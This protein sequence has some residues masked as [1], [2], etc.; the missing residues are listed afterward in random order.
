MLSGSS[1]N[2][3]ASSITN[4]AAG[5]L[6]SATASSSC[7][8][9]AT[10][11]AS[12]GGG[13]Y[14]AAPS[15]TSTGAGPALV[16]TAC[17]L[18]SNTAAGDGGG[19]TVLSGRAVLTAG[20][21]ANNI[22]GGDGGGVAVKVSTAGWLWLHLLQSHC[23]T[24]LAPPQSQGQAVLAAASVLSNTAG[25]NGGGIAFGVTSQPGLVAVYGGSVSGNTAG[26]ASLQ[27]GLGGGLYLAWPAYVVQGA[28][29][30]NNSAYTGGGLSIAADFGTSQTACRLA[31]A[32]QLPCSAPLLAVVLSGNNASA[33]L[34]LFWLRASSPGAVVACTNCTLPWPL[35]P[36][37]LATEPLSLGFATP[38]ATSVQTGSVM[39]QWSIALQD[40]YASAAATYAA[41]C[42]LAT[43]APLGGVAV[44]DATRLTVE[45]NQAV[46]ALGV[47]AFNSTPH[48]LVGTT[49]P[50]QVTCTLTAAATALRPVGFNITVAPCAAGTQVSSDGRSCDACKA[51]AEFNLQAGGTC[52]PCPLGGACPTPT[53]LQALPDWWRSTNTS[54]VLFNCPLA[55]ACLPGQP[56]GDAACL[57]GYGGPVCAVCAP[58]YYPWGKVCK[59]CDP[60]FNWSMPLVGAVAAVAFVCMFALPVKTDNVDPVVRAKL[61]MTFLQ[62]QGL[63]KDYAITWR[64]K[65]L[66][67]A[68]SYFDVLNI[69]L[70]I[71]A[72]AC[73]KA[74]LD[75]Y[76]TYLTTMMLPPAALGLCAAVWAAHRWALRGPW[77]Q[78]RPQP[79]ILF[80]RVLL[81]PR[82]ALS[83]DQ[84]AVAL[85]RFTTRCLKNA[86]WLVLL[87]YPGVCKK[88]M[89]LYGTRTL[90]TGAFLRSDYSIQTRDVVF[91]RTAKYSRYASGGIVMTLLYPAGIP[92]LFAVAVRLQSKRAAAKGMDLMDSFVG[93]LA[94]GYSPKVCVLCCAMHC[95][96]SR[97]D[98]SLPPCRL[99]TGSCWS[100]C[101]SWRWRPSACLRWT[102]RSTGATRQM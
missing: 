1:V 69:G 54:T 45:N 66:L 4:N 91:H 53:V 38:P 26:N 15:A 101:A 33:G 29:V 95:L 31:A 59:A 50:L 83:D 13:V 24:S 72:P 42:T 7:G 16:L 81:P 40:Y 63:I 98:P 37:D 56:A 102:A 39:A 82:A 18:T 30:A 93:F 73:G 57:P 46:T 28:T 5:T 78:A 60:A 2:L 85:D 79:F 64:P 14:M 20:S 55:G 97:P 88:V 19:I 58:G 76:S 35:R 22:A 67:G 43:G 34:S 12:S 32:L 49:Y 70:E 51:N 96:H 44:S 17:T 71:T 27:T 11:S 23:C 21:V 6:A 94:A 74:P 3:T 25:G 47:A 75:F 62:V 100:Y 65:L 86:A 10:S 41:T 77:R 8:A 36:S 84:V 48:G 80:G 87:L 61:V 52:R 99:C 68:L 92:L 90:D 89:Q 9:S